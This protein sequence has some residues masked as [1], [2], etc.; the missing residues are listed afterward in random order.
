MIALFGSARDLFSS[1]RR[2]MLASALCVGVLLIASTATAMAAELDGTA[3]PETQDVA[4]VHLVLNGLAL[5]TYSFLRIHIYVAALYLAQRSA[6]PDVILKSP[7]PKL[8]RFS[9]KRDIDAE[10]ARKSW[11][12]SFDANCKSPCR[13]PSEMVSRF[14]AAVPPVKSGDTGVLQFTSQGLNIITNGQTL[15]QVSD[16]AFVQVILATFIGAHPSTA[17]LKR[18][19]L[20]QSP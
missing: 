8:L 18:G 9:F 19:L 15:G 12:E 5:R 17:S 4:G 20:G 1:L 10:T 2:Q 7:E 14:L 6:D 11:R 13:L 16:P 3:M